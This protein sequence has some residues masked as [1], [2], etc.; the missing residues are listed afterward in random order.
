MNNIFNDDFQDFLKA[1]N[2]HS[3]KYLLVGGYSVI[4]HGYPRTTGDMD[5]WVEKSVENYNNI[6]NAFEEFGMPTFDMSKNN[7]LSNSNLDV[8]T[9]GRSPVAIDILTNV[10][11]LNFEEAF[12]NKLIN[13]IDNNLFVNLIHYNDLII[14]KKAAGRARDLNDIENLRK[15]E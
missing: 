2:N 11:G 4:L 14:A 1:F 12:A 5:L 10:K 9:F 3:V 7:F 8:F 13:E 15:F 6:V